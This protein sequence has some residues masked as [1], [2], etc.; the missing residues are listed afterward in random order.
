[1]V[2]SFLVLV[3][4]SARW[5][6]ANGCCDCVFHGWRNC[7]VSCSI[8]S[9][10]KFSTVVAKGVRLFC[11]RDVVTCFPMR[12]RKKLTDMVDCSSYEINPLSCPS[13]SQVYFEAH[14][15]VC[16]HTSERC[17]RHNLQVLFIGCS[18]PHLPDRNPF[19]SLYSRL[20]GLP[21]VCLVCPKTLQA[22]CQIFGFCLRDEFTR[23]LQVS[24]CFPVK[25]EVAK[26]V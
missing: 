18:F 8:W 13:L 26:Y 3:H 24:K 6:F 7:S 5:S 22:L 15:D 10:D 12:W 17:Y 11:P 20:S 19:A 4:A 9:S 2:S 14:N 1:M 16:I 25:K 21:P 23:S